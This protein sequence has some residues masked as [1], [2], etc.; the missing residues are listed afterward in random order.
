MIRLT[1]ASPELDVQGTIVKDASKPLM[2]ESASLGALIQQGSGAS[3]LG[4]SGSL[5]TISGLSGMTS[6]SVGRY[7][8][9]AGAASAGNNGEFLIHSVLFAADVQIVNPS[10]VA[11]DANNGSLSWI[12]RDPYTLAD[13]VNF[14][15]TD[16]EL[17]KG[18]GYD[19]PIPIYQ[20]PDATAS[21]VSANL[22][23]IAGKTTDAR[24]LIENRF[25]YGISVSV[26]DGFIT[27]TGAGQFPHSAS[28]N[29]TGVPC[30]DAAP[31]IGDYRS[32]YVE[33][34]DSITD[35]ELE[36]STG[37]HIGEKIFGV[38]RSGASTSPNSVEVAFYSAP[39]GTDFSITATVYNWEMGQP[40]SI[41]C[42]YGFFQ[43]IDQLPDTALRIFKG[44]HL[45]PSGSM[46]P[47]GATGPQG[48]IGSPGIQGPQGIQG[49]QGSPGIQG[50]QGSPGLTGPQGIQGSPGLTGPQGIQGSPGTAGPQGPPGVT[51]PQGEQGSPGVTG[52]QGPQGTQGSPGIQGEQGSPG[53]TGPQGIQGSP[54]ITGLQGPQ[55]TQGSPGIQGEQGSPG[56]TGTQGPQGT[57]GSPGVTGPQGAT[58]PMPSLG[59]VTPAPVNGSAPQAGVSTLAARA[60]HAHQIGFTGEAAG[61]LIVRGTAYWLNFPIGA[62]GSAFQT[63]NGFAPRWVKAYESITNGTT[64]SPSTTSGSYATIPEMTVTFTAQSLSVLVVFMADANLQNGD[65]WDFAVFLDGSI[66]SATVRH[67]EFHG[68]SGL[69]GL[70]P[71]SIDGITASIGDLITGLAPGSHTI[72][73]KW[74]VSAGTARMFDV[75]RSL[76][77]RELV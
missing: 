14:E 51:G 13:D 68:A 4:I 5:V 26:S 75:Q 38:T 3:V 17:I 73:I 27:L 48:P 42:I 22:A 53:I 24:G 21:N 36:V 62:S 65:S 60:D 35:N 41:T 34:T 2:E 7:L 72:E 9:I 71:G 16:R 33:I 18:V 56:I 44:E 40:S 55:G 76:I 58:G 29:K 45:I 52:T 64:T 28:S 59:S 12:E 77:V 25:A 23:N 67:L 66:R 70:S 61:D 54:G 31:Y 47:P 32:C 39:R 15:R 74:K 43:R 30:F 1:S 10:G 11:P 37:P 20:R 49:V 46:G 6:L 19:Q 57:Q 69:L 8:T 63:A 50:P